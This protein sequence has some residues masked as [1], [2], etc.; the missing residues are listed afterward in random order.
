MLG[1]IQKIDVPMRRFTLGEAVDFCVS[2]P[3][4]S[5]QAT[6]RQRTVPACAIA[7]IM[8]APGIG[9]VVKLAVSGIPQAV[10][11]TENAYCIPLVGQPPPRPHGADVKIEDP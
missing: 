11:R 7:S 6:Q 5:W 4:P 9:F 2:R 1:P 8:L 10:R 3:T